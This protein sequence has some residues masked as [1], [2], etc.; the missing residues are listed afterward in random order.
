[1]SKL[2]KD[3]GET[4]AVRMLPGSA[5][6]PLFAA[7]AWASIN[8]LRFPWASEA[9]LIRIS[10]AGTYRNRTGLNRREISAFWQFPDGTCNLLK[11]LEPCWPRTITTTGDR[12]P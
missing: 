3:N 4:E 9:D 12:V 2:L 6:G 1:M 5:E 11:L 10:A 7:E 8:G